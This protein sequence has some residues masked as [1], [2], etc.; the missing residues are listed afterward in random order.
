MGLHVTM[1]VVVYWID[2]PDWREEYELWKLMKQQRMKGSNTNNNREKGI[3]EDGKDEENGGL[4]TMTTMTDDDECR[5]QHPSAFT[6]RVA[7]PAIP[8]QL[9]SGRLPQQQQQQPTT[10]SCW[11]QPERREGDGGKSWHR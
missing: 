1:A 9:P 11:I 4:G 5:N 10:K 3:N 7:S 6:G 8:E 2:C